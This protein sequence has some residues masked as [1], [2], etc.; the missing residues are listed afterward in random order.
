MKGLEKATF[1]LAILAAVLGTMYVVTEDAAGE[2]PSISEL[3]DPDMY[4]FVQIDDLGYPTYVMVITCKTDVPSDLNA[5]W[6]IKALSLDGEFFTDSSM[7]AAVDIGT[8]LPAPG[9]YELTVT[10]YDGTYPVKVLDYF[11]V[12]Y[13]ANGGSGAMAGEVFVEGSDAKLAHNGF[14]A[15]KGYLFVGWALSPTDTK[16]VKVIEKISKDMTVYAT[17]RMIEESDMSETIVSQEASTKETV[18]SEIQIVTVKDSWYLLDGA[19]ITIEGRLYVPAGATLYVEPGAKLTVNGEAI[20]EGTLV[21]ED[22]A[23]EDVEDAVVELN[24]KTQVKGMIDA[25]GGELYIGGSLVIEAD[26]VMVIE[27]AAKAQTKGTGSVDVKASGSLIINGSIGFETVKNAGSVTINSM[28]APKAN[29]TIYMTASGA[30]VD[31]QNY[32]DEKGMYVLAVT[33][34]RMMIGKNEVKTGSENTVEVT[35]KS[36]VGSGTISGL[37]IT[38]ILDDDS[39]L[40][41]VSGTVTVTAQADDGTPQGSA[42]IALK[43]K[44]C[45]TV[46]DT[47]VAGDGVSVVNEGEFWIT[48][49]VEANDIVNNGWAYVEDDGL[50]KLRANG[51]EKKYLEATRY[52]TTE[53]KAKIYNYASFDSAVAKMNEEGSA[54]KEITTI[55]WQRANKSATIPEDATVVVTGE[56]YIGKGNGSDVRLEL[57]NGAKLKG[58][59]EIY[60]NGTLFANNKSDVKIATASIYSDVYAVQMENGKAVKNGWAKWTNVFTAMSEAQPSDVIEVTRDSGNLR[61]T[62]NMTIPAGVTLMIGTGKAPM[63]LSNGVTLTVNGVLDTY[64]DVYAERVFG[65]EA[66]NAGTQVSSC[67][68]VN[69]LLKA[70]KLSYGDSVAGKPAAMG[71]GAPIAGVYFAMDGRVAVSTLAVALGMIKDISS[72]LK[73]YGPV[74]AGD[75]TFVATEKC[76]TLNV[77]DSSVKDMAGNDVATKLTVGTLT[78][79]GSTLNVMAGGA[80][81]GTVMIGDNSLVAENVTG[82]EA[83]LADKVIGISGAPAAVGKSGSVTVSM[84]TV[85][86]N[87]IVTAIKFAVSA[88]A[89]LN[90]A[91]ATLDNLVIDGTVSVTGQLDSKMTTVNPGGKLSVFYDETGAKTAGI[92]NVAVLNVGITGSRYTGAEATVSGPVTVTGQ[93]F[94]APGA[95]ID[96][97]T[98]EKLDM[99][100]STAY[101]VEEKLLM[102]VYDATGTFEIAK[103]SKITVTN[104]YFDGTWLDSRGAVIASGE[105]VGSYDKVYANIVYEIYKIV[106]KADQGVDDVYLN[107][108]QMSKGMIYVGSYSYYAFFLTVKAGEYEV[109][110][111]LANGYAGEAKLYA[112]GTAQAGNKF[113]ATGTPEDSTGIT[114]EFQLSGIQKSGYVDPTEPDKKDGL[115]ITEILLI[116]LVILVVIMA[117]IVA[118]RLMRS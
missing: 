66:K 35:V 80:F 46:R 4:E 98:Q 93:A 77:T 83:K 82:F 55:E 89:T 68:V 106:I 21:I 37:K 84:G 18:F 40:M 95:V 72:D 59:G 5:R 31:I 110:Y 108:M 118:L 53:N 34:L 49:T 25:Q 71:D 48:G 112:G 45:I 16:T 107:G 20:I 92:A 102:T 10:G 54:V 73:A 101:Y 9:T 6:E 8:A 76:K 52:M 23:V 104:A 97:V 58:S 63:L 69:G 11:T 47:F 109:T 105:T 67:I 74:T 7:R 12:N 14:K 86:A 43:G 41:D 13:N 100:R 24:G 103:V 50:V 15:P 70:S 57:L 94:V 111:N 19:D 114:M 79:S 33:D 96:A 38:E 64:P 75:E 30:V 29:T 85:K 65:T 90:V 88:G 42:M 26:A 87:N 61:I 56:L 28:V 44:C 116:V 99:L 3:I 27:D 91:T 1:L 60:V 22:S 115:T 39:N 17:W 2:N 81:S 51:I 36:T 78:L 113:T 62:Q 32:T 117:V